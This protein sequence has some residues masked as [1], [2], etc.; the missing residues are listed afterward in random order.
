MSDYCYVDSL[1]VETNSILRGPEDNPQDNYIVIHLH[2]DHLYHDRGT[3]T[4][5]PGVQ[6]VQAFHGQYIRNNQRVDGNSVNTGGRQNRGRNNRVSV[7]EC[8]IDQGGNY[9]YWYPGYNGEGVMLEFGRAI[10]NR[11]YVNMDVLHQ[12][13]ISNYQLWVEA[14]ADMLS[15]L[16]RERKMTVLF[17]LIS[18]TSMAGMVGS[19]IVTMLMVRRG[20]IRT[21]IRDVASRKI[22]MYKYA[23]NRTA[24]SPEVLRK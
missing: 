3:N 6:T 7:L 24:S 18:R 15:R 14:W 9:E 2:I 12:V 1:K 4:V 13:C 21:A 16:T 23:T 5:Y 10:M 20:L 19:R 22:S 17:P 11:H 8:Q